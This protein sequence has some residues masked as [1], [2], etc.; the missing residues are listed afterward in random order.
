MVE[1]GVTL[2]TSEVIIIAIC[3]SPVLLKI[4]FREIIPA[5]F[6]VPSLTTGTPET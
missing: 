6:M 5:N 2:T 4:S 1:L 3:S